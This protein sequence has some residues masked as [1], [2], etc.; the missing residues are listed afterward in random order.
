MGCILYEMLT[1]EVPFVADTFMG[2]LTKQMFEQPIPPRKLRPDLGIPEPLEQVILKSLE[3]EPDAR[4]RTVKEMVLALD[5]CFRISEAGPVQRVP[6]LAVLQGADAA[7]TDDED[8]ETVHLLVQQRTEPEPLAGPPPR[9]WPLAAGIATFLVLAS[10]GVYWGLIHRDEP[11]PSAPNVAARPLDADVEAT[12]ASTASA[13]ANDS[14]PAGIDARARTVMIQLASN[15]GGATVTRDR[16]HM[17][18]TPL[19]VRVP[20]GKTARFLLSKRG[21]HPEMLETTPRRHEV[22][23]VRLRRIRRPKP[24]RPD[25]GTKS[26]P[27]LRDLRNPFDKTG[28]A[29]RKSP[30]ND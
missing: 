13:P 4:F 25:A 30:T 18:Q 29:R 8:R 23:T 21:F 19:E 1:G 20:V 12:L 9:R 17:G 16:R 15:P 6:S 24:R 26:G 14:T 10:F 5:S 22:L 2:T 3:K 27:S 7:A 11:D 28:G